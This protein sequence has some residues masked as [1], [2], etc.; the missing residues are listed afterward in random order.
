MFIALSLGSFLI[1]L[2]VNQTKE[3]KLEKPQI[4]DTNIGLVSLDQFENQKP[5]D[6]P[7][8]ETD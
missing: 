7:D 8:S 4:D 5:D 6:Q 1:Y 2:E 3:K